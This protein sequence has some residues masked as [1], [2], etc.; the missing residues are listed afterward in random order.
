MVFD[1][2]EKDVDDKI[3]EHIVNRIKNKRKKYQQLS[4]VQF[5]SSYDNSLVNECLAN[6]VRTVFAKPEKGGD[7]FVVKRIQFL[8]S[9]QHYI[10]HYFQEQRLNSVGSLKKCSFRF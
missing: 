1:S 10:R 3:K 5:L 6:D 4:I 2:P 8:N 9:F 7:D